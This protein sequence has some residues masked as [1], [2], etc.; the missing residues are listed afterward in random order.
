MHPIAGLF[1]KGDSAD[2]AGTGMATDA[3]GNVQRMDT[4]YVPLVVNAPMITYSLI[5]GPNPALKDVPVSPSFVR[6]IRDTLGEVVNPLNPAMVI[7][8]R[9]NGYD[10][11]S[12]SDL[13]V[14]I[15]DP[16]GRVIKKIVHQNC[17]QIVNADQSSSVYGFAWDLTNNNG[18]IVGSG[19]YAAFVKITTRKSTGESTVDNNRLILA[20]Q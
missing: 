18:R 14:M 12:T 9:T 6:F 8:V 16:L 15:C 13:D 10:P 11:A 19:S 17:R 5:V 4:R 3:E 1:N 7:F 20:V 2:L